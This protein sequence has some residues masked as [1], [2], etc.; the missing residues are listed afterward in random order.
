[1]HLEKLSQMKTTL[2]S[3]PFMHSLEE[4]RTFFLPLPSTHMR[5][6]KL[7][8]SDFFGLDFSLD[9]YVS[10]E[11]L[12]NIASNYLSLILPKS[13]PWPLL[14]SLLRTP[15]MPPSPISALVF[16]FGFFKAQSIILSELRPPTLSH[17]PSSSLHV[18]PG[19]VDIW[20]WWFI[21]SIVYVFLWVLFYVFLV[22]VTIFFVGVWDTWQGLFEVRAPSHTLWLCRFHYA[23][24]IVLTSGQFFECSCKKFI[25]SNY[26]CDAFFFF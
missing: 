18:P 14:Y 24:S 4:R 26:S 8:L 10:Y 15:T 20:V 22:F 6:I 7:I 2:A 23:L 13:Q 19:A 25:G 12:S 9:P 11:A 5:I 16:R 3:H 21:Y 1:M 17:V